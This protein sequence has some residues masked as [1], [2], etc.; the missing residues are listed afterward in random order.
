MFQRITIQ[1]TGPVCTCRAQK[2]S[3][4]IRQDRNGK[5]ALIIG[6]NLCGTELY[7]PNKKFVAAFSLRNPYPAG[8]QSDDESELPDNVVKLFPR[9][10]E[11][12]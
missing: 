6:C 1:L 5:P 2:L 9:D 3:W 11:G 12:A 10:P 4:N 7:V 8:A